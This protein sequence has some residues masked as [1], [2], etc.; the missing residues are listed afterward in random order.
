[1]NPFE[2]A[3][4]EAAELRKELESKGVD[5]NQGGFDLVTAACKVLG[6]VLRQVKPEMA[7]LK[8][9]DAT[10]L[11]ERKWTLVRKDVPDDIKAFLVAH[12]IGHFRLHPLTK[13]SVEVNQSALTGET[14]SNGVSVVES[15]GARERQELQAN[16]FAREFLLPRRDARDAFLNHDQ[17]A[18]DLSGL[19]KL[20]L[21]LVRLQL[22]DGILLPHVDKPAKIFHLPDEPTAAQQPAV[23]SDA[24]V[25]LIEAG[26]GTGKTTTLLLRLRRLIL[27]G[28][29]PDEIVIL[30]FSN[31]AARELV[32]RARSGNIPGADRVWI[33]TFHAFGLEFLRKFGHLHGL[34]SRFPVL[35]KLASL[36]M[37]EQD[38]PN[39]E[40]R[41]HDALSKPSWLESIVDAIRRSKDEVF[42]AQKFADAVASSPS[43]R[44][45]QPGPSGT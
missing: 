18:T 16:V 14:E 42:D 15:Y 39:A 45:R 44:G 25:S 12:E 37:L 30:T 43:T 21:E 11:V 22:Y 35:D 41:F 1:M 17:S 3:R 26:P 9:A 32:E 27:S 23:D 19:R 24:P 33:G 34:E 38:V 40:L 8:S 2:A 5:L 4:L 36:A 31:K 6:I 28:V 20:P 13:G 29:S 7:L 10:I